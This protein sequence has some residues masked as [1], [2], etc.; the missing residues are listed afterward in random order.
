WEML[1]VDDASVE[2]GAREILR[3]AE[4]LDPRIRVIRKAVNG[5]T[6]RARNTSLLQA[7]GAFMTFLDSDDWAHPQR[8]EEG[9][10]PMLADPGLPATRSFGARVTESLELTRPGYATHFS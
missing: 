5:G 6:Y 4:T 3:A 8:L 7:R 2:P 9:V 10:R 1:I